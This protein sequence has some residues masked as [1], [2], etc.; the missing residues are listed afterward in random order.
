MDVSAQAKRVNSSFLYLFVL[1][2]PS[3][4]WKMPTH[5]GEG[6]LLYDVYWFKCYF[7]LKTLSQ[8]HPEIMFY[9]LSGHPLALSSWRIKLNHQI[10]F[11]Y[12]LHSTLLSQ[13]STPQDSFSWLLYL[14]R[15]LLTLF[16]PLFCFTFLSSSYTSCYIY[17]PFHINLLSV[18]TLH[19][20]LNVRF[21]EEELCLSHGCIS[22][23]LNNVWQ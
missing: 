6:D 3:K 23:T 2:R 18:S 4:D 22:S 17:I 14:Q 9:R 15:Q 16:I 21:W 5:F 13:I 10:W 19:T 8:T 20:L 11:T 1:F 7:L 12:S